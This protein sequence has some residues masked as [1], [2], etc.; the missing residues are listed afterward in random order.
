VFIVGILGELMELDE[1]LLVRL[2]EEDAPD[3]F[4]LDETSGLAFRVGVTGTVLMT[5]C[6]S[7]TVEGRGLGI[8]E[9]VARG[10]LGEE[11]NVDG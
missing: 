3:E 10:I 8:A 11:A 2:G 9:G 4:V 5:F 1:G 7:G 6:T